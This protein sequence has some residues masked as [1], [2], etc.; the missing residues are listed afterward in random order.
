[1]REVP[2]QI[3]N[4]I[5]DWSSANVDL[6]LAVQAALSG[7]SGVFA[8]LGWTTLSK[9]VGTI[10]ALDLGRVVRQLK[11]RRDAARKAGLI[12]IAAI[13]LGCSGAAQ[14][15]SVARSLALL[16]GAVVVTDAALAQTIAALPPGTDLAPWRA[17]VQTLV[18]IADKIRDGAAT[19][20]QLCT[21]LPAVAT[22]ASAA[23]CPECSR[24]VAAVDRAVCQ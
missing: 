20:E 9:I 10:A 1:M 12:A 6:L 17:R 7:F 16:E 15:P 2:M 19:V 24:A 23:E 21:D 5:V 3:L 22:I 14:P 13:A 18:T 4:S 8:I 11:A